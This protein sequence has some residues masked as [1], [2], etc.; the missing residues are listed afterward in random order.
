MSNKSVLMIGL[1]PA[2]VNYERW[3][4][5][6]AEKLEAG[7]RRDEAALNDSGYAAEICFIDHG[8]TAEETVKAKLAE[9]DFA[10]VMIGAGVRTDTEEFL[11]FEKLINV[12][13][14]NAPA[15]KICFNTGP[16][17]S[18]EAVQRWV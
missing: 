7:L 2:V 15:A 16:T 3:P 8:E 17:D 13:H 4:G 10:C 12:L 11:L 1:D 14:E 9:K 5:L 6:T 18:V